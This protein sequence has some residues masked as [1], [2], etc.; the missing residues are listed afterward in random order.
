M[1]LV[2]KIILEY[3]AILFFPSVLSLQLSADLIQGYSHN[4]FDLVIVSLAPW[5]DFQHLALSSDWAR[6]HRREVGVMHA[7]CSGSAL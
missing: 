1:T 5:N 4:L 3:S 7:N 6:I 2:R